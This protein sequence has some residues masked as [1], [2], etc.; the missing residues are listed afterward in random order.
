MPYFKETTHWKKRADT[1][2]KSQVHHR[3]KGTFSIPSDATKIRRKAGAKRGFVFF[4]TLRL[5]TS[6]LGSRHN[7]L[8]RRMALDWP[9]IDDIV[10]TAT[11]RR[12]THESSSTSPT[13][14]NLGDSQ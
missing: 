12:P 2:L 4:G 11:S 10:V 9:R 1:C 7:D 6:F 3:A 14:S 5:I 8:K 13:L